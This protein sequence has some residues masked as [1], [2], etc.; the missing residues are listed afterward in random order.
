MHIYVYLDESGDEGWN[1]SHPYQQGGSSKY[2]SVGYIILP[3]E[4]KHIPKK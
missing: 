1:F 4:K 3:S 2:L